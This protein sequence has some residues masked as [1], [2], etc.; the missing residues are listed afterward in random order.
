LFVGVDY[1]SRKTSV[2]IISGAGTLVTCEDLVVSPSRRD[3][4]LLVLGEFLDYEITRHTAPMVASVEG[5]ILGRSLNAQTLANLGYTA[6]VMVHTLALRGIPTTLVPSA[7]W[8]KIVL[9]RGNATKDDVM[10]W[11]KNRWPHIDALTQD[12]ADAIALAVH[13]KIT[14]GE[15]NG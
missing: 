3:H 6:G 11:A 9:G 12:Q 5:A 1:G 8:K 4:E 10:L 2:A 15:S 13:A 14:K 7:T